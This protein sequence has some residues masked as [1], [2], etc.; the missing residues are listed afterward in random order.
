MIELIP[1][2]KQLLVIIVMWLVILPVFCLLRIYCKLFG[3]KPKSVV[4]ITKIGLWTA[5]LL[6]ASI[7]EIA[8]VVL[9][10]FYA[11]SLFYELY[12]LFELRSNK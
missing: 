4:V 1:T 10:T 7:L 5:F 12:K 9:Y 6:L 11:W 2:P 3:E 8:P